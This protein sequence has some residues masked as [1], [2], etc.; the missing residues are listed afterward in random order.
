ML[1]YKNIAEN[2]AFR[3]LTFF[4]IAFLFS[5]VCLAAQAETEIVYLNF[6]TTGSNDDFAARCQKRF[7]EAHLKWKTVSLEEFIGKTVQPTKGRVLLIPESEHFP[8]PAVVGL[9]AYLKSGGNVI[10]VGRDR[11]FSSPAVR[12]GNQ[13]VTMEAF[14]DKLKTAAPSRDIGAIGKGIGYRLQ[15]PRKTNGTQSSAKLSEDGAT[16]SVVA[17][18]YTKWET[19]ATP[20]N[21]I[22]IPADTEF[23]RLEVRGNIPSLSLE[24]NE[25]DGSRW[26][27]TFPV[28][29]DWQTR[30]VPLD[31]F[32][33][34]SSPKRAGK[35]DRVRFENVH[36]A[37]IGISDTHTRGL[38]SGKTYRY[39]IRKIEAL[40]KVSSSDARIYPSNFSLE[41]IAPRYKS[42]VLDGPVTVTVGDKKFDH[43]ESVVS[44]IPRMLGHGI[45][46]KRPWR[47]IPVA[48]AVNGAGGRAYPIW[49]M[50]HLD[51]QYRGAVVAGMGFSLE[52]IVREPNLSGE[53]VEL[54]RK[55]ADG[56][57]L[58]GAGAGDFIVD[59]GGS[60]Q[61]G[62]ELF[63]AE[64][65]T[66]V[67]ARIQSPEGKTVAEFEKAADAEENP[68]V[69]T[70]LPRP[71][72]YAC[73]VELLDAQNRIVD[74]IDSEI[75]VVDGKPD[76]LTEFV[77]TEKDNF[78]LNGK[79]WYP[80]SVNFYP[81]YSV[82][83]AEPY[84]YQSGWGDRRYYDP[85]WVEQAILD[86]RSA[87]L[88]M[89][90]VHPS[91]QRTLDPPAIRDFLYRCR[92]HGMKVNLFHG[93]ASPLDF[94]EEVFRNFV[95]AARLRDDATLFCYDIIWEPTNYIYRKDFR[96]RFRPEWNRW[97][98]GQY[99][100]RQN[101][102]KDWQ[103]DP[104][105]DPDG[106]IAPP[107]DEQFKTDGDHRVFV[108]V[109]RR[110]MDDHTAQLWQRAVNR[111]R[112]VDPNHLITNRA[113]NIHSYDNAFTGPVKA[114]DFISPEGYT[115]QGNQQGEGAV[116]FATRVI[117]F[118][119]G[120]KPIIWSEY[121]R[122]VVDAEFLPDAVSLEKYGSYNELFYRRGLEA[123]AQ[124]FAP[125]WW[126][127]G[128]R[129]NERS[130]FGICNIDGTLR[131]PAE[132]A[133][134]YAPQIQTPRDRRA[135]TVPFEFDPDRHSGGYPELVFGSG[136]QAYLVAAEKGEMLKF[137]TEAEGKTSVDVPI[138]GVGNVPYSGN[139]PVKYLNGLFEKVEY[140]NASGQWIEIAD[141]S[142]VRHEGPLEI[143]ARIAN[144]GLVPFIASDATGGVT[145]RV[146]L[147]GKTARF[148]IPAD[149]P[150]LRDTVVT[151]MTIPSKKAGVLSFRFEARDRAVFGEE[152]RFELER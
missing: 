65:G 14:L 47:F 34:W 36:K 96:E 135:G 67:R 152:F 144:M 127:G 141:G 150:R 1:L 21:C 113:G 30:L 91:D 32:F 68:V 43:P 107:T 132:I 70:E 64:M 136:G 53:L 20:D 25:K 117:D 103:F 85:V 76:S 88:N 124:G 137:V 110:F 104:G 111:I 78:I 74:R 50:L 83:G 128:Y 92:K 4:L 75:V 109:Y 22:S 3:S 18:G 138:R 38:E 51:R 2:T 102:V 69:T 123:G 11:P 114:L 12:D 28:T 13:W 44:A 57:F 66:K 7:D 16:L 58:A 48:K 119:S 84:D 125:W 105:A 101:A 72:V 80:N 29:D 79:K 56:S 40:S 118:Y 149:L 82:A 81:I 145:I 94:K 46:M 45:T 31:H 62:A 63:N 54:A 106:R 59:A 8:V 60:V 129:V 5:F 142:T 19:W 147:D 73:Q 133:K 33:V 49:I 61:F 10:F 71:G 121:G 98:D 37:V 143:R 97:L 87:G 115:V 15:C 55:M 86:A 112:A 89:L 116:G 151:D 134:K 130:D 17:D 140:K 42:Y 27:G 23:I 24:L 122:S 90:S 146:D 99:G 41:G 77:R 100:N 120:G 39:E 9:E 26:I 35:G 148:P 52:T 93:S 108:A 126:P 6:R 131:P 139:N 95:E